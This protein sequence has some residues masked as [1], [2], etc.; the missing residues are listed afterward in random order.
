MTTIESV[1]E[2]HPDCIVTVEKAG[3]DELICVW[4]DETADDPWLVYGV[5]G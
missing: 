5:E 1:R 3:D 2:Q 4:A